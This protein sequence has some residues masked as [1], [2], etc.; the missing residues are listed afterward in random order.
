MNISL[1]HK[2]PKILSLIVEYKVFNVKFDH[3]CNII[4]QFL[5]LI[6]EYQLCNVKFDHNCN[7]CYYL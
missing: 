4:V 7:N 2:Y 3:N 6:V 1:Q 5:P